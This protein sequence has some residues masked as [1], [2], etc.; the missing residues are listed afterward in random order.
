MMSL[1]RDDMNMK[2]HERVDH[3]RSKSYPN[4]RYVW[5]V[6]DSNDETEEYLRR[7]SIHDNRITVIRH[8]THVLGEHPDVRLE[9]LSLT[10]NA[11][12]M[13]VRKK[14]T[15][16]LHHESDLITPHDIV[17]QLLATGRDVVGGWVTL[18]DIFYD[19][20]LYRKD[21]VHFTNHAPYHTC[22]KPDELFE[23]DSIGSV[24]L[25]PA[26]AGVYC[27]KGG[28]VEIC[29]QLKAQGYSIWCDPR[30]KIIQPHDLFTSRSH[31]SA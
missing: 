17:E 25:Y 3:L 21:G 28:L 5:V 29:Q 10:L 19:T 16:I 2:I 14:D 20:Y 27:Q 23:L 1:W 6:G 31:A 11:G 9:R 30:I 7:T 26:R 15:Y 22:Y 8:D 12:L 4:L 24:V 13:A 18:G